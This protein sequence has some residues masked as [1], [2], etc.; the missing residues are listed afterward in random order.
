MGHVISKARIVVDPEMIKAIMEWPVPKS[1][2][3][4]RSL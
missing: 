3:E 1:V 2:E 4:V